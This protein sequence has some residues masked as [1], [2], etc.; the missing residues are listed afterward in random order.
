MDSSG[1]CNAG[2]FG[3]GDLS[4]FRTQSLIL[5]TRTNTAET[6]TS[7]EVD[8]TRFSSN[9]VQTH[10]ASLLTKSNKALCA[11]IISNS[12]QPTAPIT[13]SKGV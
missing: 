1:N 3:G 6:Q 13:E 10:R 11:D 7:E 5:T 8:F 2:P 9:V 4:S 12:N